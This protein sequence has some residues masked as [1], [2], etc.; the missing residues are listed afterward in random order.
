MRPFG[1]CK[2]NAR[3]STGAGKGPFDPGRQVVTLPLDFT[4]TA[5]AGGADQ[6]TGAFHVTVFD[7]YGSNADLI[8]ACHEL[9]YID[10]LV[11]DP[12]YGRGTF[13]NRFTPER[14]RADRFGCLRLA[15]RPGMAFGMPMR[16]GG[17]VFML[18][19]EPEVDDGIFRECM[20]L[21]GW[22]LGVL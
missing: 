9:G 4:I 10:G 19:M 21:K 13:W 1:G 6:T 15:E 3:R 8:V 22:R 17:P 20:E 16:P 5:T 2:R 11:L 14:F 12:T 7:N 18:Q